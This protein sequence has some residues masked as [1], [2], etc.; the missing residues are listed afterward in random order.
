MSILKGHQHDCIEP[1]RPYDETGKYVSMQCPYCGY[2]V[3]RYQGNKLW[4]CDGLADP[5]RDD[6]DLETCEWFHID[7]QPAVVF[8]RGLAK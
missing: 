7:G 2:G 4:A 6:K 5:D 8:E 3:L 1:Q